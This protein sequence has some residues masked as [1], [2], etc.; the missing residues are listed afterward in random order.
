MT[1]NIMGKG[2]VAIALVATL[3]GVAPAAAGCGSEAARNAAQV[4]NLQTMMMVGTLQCRVSKVDVVTGYNAFVAARR[5]DLGVANGALKAHFN[6]ASATGQTAYDRYTTSL[7]NRFGEMKATDAD[8]RKLAAL[9]RVAAKLDLET[10][11]SLAEAQGLSVR[12]DEDEACAAPAPI[13]PTPPTIEIAQIDDAPTLALAAPVIAPSAP[14]AA[15]PAPMMVYLATADGKPLGT[16]PAGTQLI[17]ASAPAAT[18]LPATP[19]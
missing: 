16:L 15:A 7:A 2:K 5:A 4:R 13:A 18:A 19:R 8:C 3:C 6:V 14:P 12:L 17:V 1:G 9:T 10:L 11:L